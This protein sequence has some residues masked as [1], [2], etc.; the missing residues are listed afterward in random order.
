[1]NYYETTRHH[2]YIYHDPKDAALICDCGYGDIQA[3]TFLKHLQFHDIHFNLLDPSDRD[4]LILSYWYADVP[5]FRKVRN[6]AHCHFRSPLKTMP[7][8]CADYQNRLIEKPAPRS[9]MNL[10]SP[11]SIPM[12]HPRPTYAA[13]YNDMSRPPRFTEQ[14]RHEPQPLRPMA[15]FSQSRTTTT[16]SLA[17][18]NPDH[19]IHR[20]QRHDNTSLQSFRHDESDRTD[21]KQPIRSLFSLRVEHNVDPR[22]R[23]KYEPQRRPQIRQ[24]PPNNTTRHPPGLSRPIQPPRPS[25]PQLRSPQVQPLFRR[26]PEPVLPYSEHPSAN[27]QS[28][29]QP[30]PISPT[31]DRKHPDSMQ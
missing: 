27:Y 23:E 30:T 21:P 31:T 12:Q 4:Q 19:T 26:C 14:A 25:P 11:E 7:H 2:D 17:L 1:M 29:Y 16:R 22:I 10:L 20:R 3:N 18:S 5:T 13:E 8:R 9:F 28:N 6:C 15:M 24:P